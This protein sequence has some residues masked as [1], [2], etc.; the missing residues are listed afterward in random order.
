MRQVSRR[1]AERL[2]ATGEYL[3]ASPD[4]GEVEYINKRTGQV[5]SVPK[6]V[7]PGWAYNPGQ[8]SRLAQAQQ[9]LAEKEAAADGDSSPPE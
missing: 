6:G 8:V 9:L 5:V 7:E 3:N 4:L 2:L 1:E